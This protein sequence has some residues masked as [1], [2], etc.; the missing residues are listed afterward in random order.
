MLDTA[1]NATNNTKFAGAWLSIRVNEQERHFGR[2]EQEFRDTLSRYVNRGIEAYALMHS[3]AFLEG[4]T[5][6][7]VEKMWKEFLDFSAKLSS[8]KIGGAQAREAVREDTL[9]NL[10]DLYSVRPGYEPTT[11]GRYSDEFDYQQTTSGEHLDEPS[12]GRSRRRRL[13]TGGLAGYFGLWDG[14]P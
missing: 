3:G 9:T 12:H 8:L 6:K 13:A 7:N 2:T 14:W 11:L 10:G 5:K 1:T 4:P